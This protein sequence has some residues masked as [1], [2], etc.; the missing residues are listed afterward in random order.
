MVR[1]SHAAPQSIIWVANIS[2]QNA[3]C[4]ILW[5]KKEKKKKEVEGDY[6]LL[7]PTTP[8]LRKWWDGY[9]WKT[10]T[11]RNCR[12]PTSNLTYYPFLIHL[13]SICLT[14]QTIGLKHSRSRKWWRRDCT[15]ALMKIVARWNKI[16]KRIKKTSDF[17]Q[18]RRYSVLW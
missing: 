11:P 2:G 4:F 7:L 3:S 16:W 18:H 13:I 10:R 15:K 9:W 6:C 12:L 17:D 8:G 1:I 5:W 14:I